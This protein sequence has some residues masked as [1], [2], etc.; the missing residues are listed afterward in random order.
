MVLFWAGFVSVG[1]F[2]HYDVG[3]LYVEGNFRRVMVSG[4]GDGIPFEDA[5]LPLRSYVF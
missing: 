4:S 5:K 1:K 3:G 2:G